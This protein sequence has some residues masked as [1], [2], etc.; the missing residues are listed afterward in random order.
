M[1]A[2]QA[3]C[4]TVVEL[5][6]R[7][8]AGEPDRVAYIFLR[9]GENEEMR[10]TYEELDR[11]ARA[12]ASLLSSS[13]AYGKRALLLYP[14]GLEYII[15]F[16][17]CLYAGAVAVPCF[18]PRTN[19]PAERIGAIAKDSGAEIILTTG[20]INANLPDRLR[21]APYLSDLAW[22]SEDNCPSGSE[23]RWKEPEITGDSLAFLQYTSGSTSAPKG[24]MVSHHNILHN[25]GMLQKAFRTD[26]QSVFVSWLPLFHDMGL[27]AIVLHA[28]Y[29]GVPCIFMSPESFLQKPLR[30]LQAITRY[31]GT[32]CGAPN[33]AYDLCVAKSTPE[34]REHLDLSSWRTAFNG[35]EPVRH[36]TLK[37]FAETF[38][39]CGFAPA[40]LYPCYGLAEATVIVSGSPDAGMPVIRSFSKQLLERDN[41]AVETEESKEDSRTLVACGRAINDEIILVVDPEN[42]RECPSGR[43]GEIWVAGRHVAQ[44][45]WNRADATE[46]TFRAH[47]SDTGE[48]PFMRTGDLGFF[49]RGDLFIAGRLKDLII[50]QGHNYH[51]HDIELTVEQSHGTLRQ[52]SGAAFSLEVDGAEKLV[53]VQEMSRH[54]R[55]VN[56]EDVRDAIIWAVAR[57]HGLR[58]H[59]VV[60]VRSHSIPKTSSGKIMR[61]ACRLAFLAGN[62]NVIGGMQ[63]PG[64]GGPTAEG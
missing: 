45:Y 12:T 43:V 61:H 38:A 40:A 29:V 34:S 14:S 7:R 24:V 56:V 58:P 1:R 20:A 48:G 10:L 25:A 28:L 33:F 9:D 51:P 21:H 49:H 63:G 47:L 6:R 19:R 54:A 46:S 32:L 26:R 30:W 11:R 55:K 22:L 52:D 60:L 35:A 42:L 39:P 27:I 57:E 2:S 4:A 17:G 18:P 41:S 3:D 36:T 50:I 8:A 31:G 16:F 13:V 23:V 37:R 59:A 62:L 53:V 44:G 15:S 64:K 5:L